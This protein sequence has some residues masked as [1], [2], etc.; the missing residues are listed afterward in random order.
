[1]ANRSATEIA[2]DVRHLLGKRNAVKVTIQ[3]FRKMSKR[4]NIRDTFIHYDVNE[5]LKKD[6]IIAQ[7]WGEEVFF[8][9][10]RRVTD[11]YFLTAAQAKK[12]IRAG[13]R[14]EGAIVPRIYQR[15]TL[16]K[17]AAC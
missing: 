4:E 17:R 16:V 15:L 2:H 14:A 7:R 11:K 12:K 5:E 8:M 9:K 3:Y 1:M 13:Y 6:G 10:W